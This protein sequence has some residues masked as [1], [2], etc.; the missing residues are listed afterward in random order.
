M[1][2]GCFLQR[3]SAPLSLSWPTGGRGHV[4]AGVHGIW[5]LLA[6]AL[7]WSAS[8]A[9]PLPAVLLIVAI[10]SVVS[11]IFKPGVSS[12]LPQLV[13]GPSELV[14]ANA[15]GSL[16]EATGTVAGPALAG[17]LLAAFEPAVT[18]LAIALLS[19]VAAAVSLAIR[20]EFQPAR[21]VATSGLRRL[22]EPLLG[23]AALV[24]GAG[25][26][27]AFALFMAQCVMRGLLNVY[28]VVLA[29]TGGG[30]EGLTSALFAAMG[31]GGVVGALFALSIG[32]TVHS[33]RWLAFGVAMWGL[34]VLI[35]GLWPVQPVALLALVVLGF[36]NA[37]LDVFGFTVLHRLLPDHVS[38]R[39]FG[40]FWST[41]AAALAAGSALAPILISALGLDWAMRLSGVVLALLPAVFWPALRRIDDRAGSVL[42]DVALLAG[43]PL[44]G[45]MSAIG[46]ERLAAGAEQR[47]FEA[48]EVVLR[49]GELGDSFY[50]IAEGAVVVTQDGRELR[51]MQQGQA[52]GE[53]ALLDAV[54]RT[55]TVTSLRPSRLFCVDGPT[56]VAAVTGHR[57]ADRV[58]GE[59][60]ARW[61]RN[62]PDPPSLADP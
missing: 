20:T 32:S 58:A 38:G 31:V 34:P 61:L 47:R 9:L 26:P 15:A 36:G 27:T 62:E 55:A 22:A 59:T 49:Q 2:C 6:L 57:G 42:D 19:A 8:A 40:A 54:P 46:L 60:V 39:A 33:A 30:G 44:L 37:V 14:A 12:L 29:L 18:F 7:A 48:G 17:V 16:V 41:A 4:L 53:V 5:V 28:L 56:F 3:S 1:S 43:V 50:V 52:F 45:P 21:S 35:I 25:T 13:N 51:T 10:G 11:G 24:T 23:F